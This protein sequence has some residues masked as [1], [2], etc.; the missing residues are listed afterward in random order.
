MV[1]L[2]REERGR[3]GKMGEGWG[4]GRDSVEEK[5]EGR[6]SCTQAQIRVTS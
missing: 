6:E 1:G 5:S 4:G 3:R 2:G